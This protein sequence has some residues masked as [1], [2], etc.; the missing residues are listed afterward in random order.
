[1]SQTKR[2]QINIEE[3]WRIISKL[4]SGI[5]NKDLVKEYGVSHSTISTIWREREKIH[6]LYEKNFLKMKRARRT[7][8]TKIEDALLEWLKYQ[9]ANNVPINGPTLKQK[10]NDFAQHL[11][12]DFVCS[13]SWI[14]RF[15]A[16]CG[17]RKMSGAAVGVSKG[18]VE[19]WMTQKWPTLCEGY[20]PE[21]IFNAAETGLFYNMT[22]DRTLFF[23]G[24]N[25]LGGKMSK[26]RLTIMVAA[27]M[28]GSCKRKLLVIGKYKKSRC[29]K[30]IHSLAV[31]YENNVKS[32]MTSEIF[33]RWLRN[34]DTELITNNK[35]VLLL[36]DNCPAHPTVTNLNCIKVVFLPSNDTSVLQ[37]MNQGV[38]RCL[39]SHYRKLQLL[40]LIQDL[41]SN[42]QTSFTI[43]DAIL[44]IS[45]A[46]EKVSQKTIV[47]CFRRAGFKYFIIL[48]DVL[49]DNEEDNIPLAKLAQHL[50]PVLSSTEA[51]HFI[52]V[53]RSIAICAPTTEDDIKQ[54]VQEENDEQD[55]FEEQF[56]VP[57]L[58]EGLNA[59][60]VLRK[61]ILFNEQFHMQ[62]N[63][64]YTLM[65]IQRNLQNVY[66]QEKC[67][68]PI[69]ITDSMHMDQ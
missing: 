21:D 28:T 61:I 41:D 15:R 26:M 16:R 34:W 43:L 5:P 69:K 3:K 35:K 36:I 60:S 6:T 23:K 19:E 22:P 58:S 12:E 14:Q 63:C 40:K 38:I 59:I 18:A 31:T 66:V 49:D 9:R 7:K 50:R 48:D 25:C 10:A 53:D 68:K 33:E 17:I 13:P 64:D 24:E 42:N 45:E 27:N 30:N 47:N 39:K 29:F 62:K 44:M 2:K 55:D 52:N 8:H 65:K 46:W 11:G 20:R 1:M 32:W 57:T 51:D 37:P 54:E 67:F 4:E 56:T